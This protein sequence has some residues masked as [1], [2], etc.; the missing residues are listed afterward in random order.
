MRLRFEGRV[1]TRDFYR[2][3]H[4]CLGISERVGLPLHT[5]HKEGWYTTK[6]NL[7]GNMQRKCRLS[8]DSRGQKEGEK[9]Q[10]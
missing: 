7:D 5:P 1:K 3:L 8:G 6:Q 9:V 10:E 2:G 4:L